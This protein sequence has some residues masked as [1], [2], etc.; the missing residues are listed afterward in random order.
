LELVE[1]KSSKQPYPAEK[2]V[3]WRLWKEAFKLGLITY[4]SQGCA[5]GRNGDLLILGPP[6]IIREEELEQIVSKL[7][8]A[9]SIFFGPQ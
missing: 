7:Q 8:Q 6:L 2:Q 9:I 1:E 4:T 3:A 5:D